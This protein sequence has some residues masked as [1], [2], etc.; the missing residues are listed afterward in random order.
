MRSNLSRVLRAFVLSGLSGLV[1]IVQAG[2]FTVYAAASLTE[3]MNELAGNW[4]RLHGHEV[5]LSFAASSTLATQIE[6]GAPAAIFVAADVR[7]MD[8]LEQLQR[9]VTGSRVDLLGN[10][11]V[12]VMPAG[13]VRPVTLKPGFD[14][15]GLL[16]EG[17]LATG[18]PAHVPVGLYAQQALTTLGVWPDS[19]PRLVRAESV[20]AAIVFVAR[21]E[22]PAGIVYATDAAISTEV[23]IAGTFPADSHAPIVYPMALIAEHTT[24]AARA[25]HAWLQSEDAMAVFIRYGFQRAPH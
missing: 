7:S 20:R 18:D 21:G 13:Q 11:L 19:E 17:R 8:Y 3:A 22:V 2:T 14:L 16:G 10:T 6:A 4:G 23:G 9:L 5:K 24:P 25:L 15:L 12:L 1:G